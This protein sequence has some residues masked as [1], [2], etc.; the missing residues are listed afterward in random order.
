MSKTLDLGKDA[1]ELIDFLEKQLM[2]RNP[3]GNE[4]I[5]VTLSVLAEVYTTVGLTAQYSIKQLQ[6]ALLTTKQVMRKVPKVF[7]A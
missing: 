4:H 3:D 2:N 6:D 5:A 7:D 1:Q